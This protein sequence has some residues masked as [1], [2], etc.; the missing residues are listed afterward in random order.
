MSE[1]K[2]RAGRG[3]RGTAL[4]AVLALCLAALCLLA[5]GATYT[6]VAAL[7]RAR[8]VQVTVQRIGERWGE[9]KQEAAT[10]LLAPAGLEAAQSWKRLH[11]D[12]DG[13]FAS[14]RARAAA[15]LAAAAGPEAESSYRLLNQ[16]QHIVH[17]QLTSVAE[18]LTRAAAPAPPGRAGSKLRAL[19][20]YQ[21]RG[22]PP[23]DRTLYAELRTLLRDSAGFD[24]HLERLSDGFGS[25]VQR[26]RR[27]LIGLVALSALV[28]LALLAAVYRDRI[29]YLVRERLYRSTIGSLAEGV[30]I[31]DKKGRLIHANPAARA[32]LGI[33]ERS[34]RLPPPAVVGELFSE[35]HARASHP[36]AVFSVERDGREVGVSRSPVHDR[37]GRRIGDA[38]VLR[39]VTAWMREDRQSRT[40]GRMQ[41]VSSFAGGLA[42]DFNNALAGIQGNLELLALDD[43][44]RLI[45]KTKDAI[46]RARDLSRTLLTFAGSPV[47]RRTGAALSVEALL[48][49]ALAR[50]DRDDPSHALRITREVD[51][52]LPPISGDPARLEE[53]VYAVLR[54][55]AEA[56]QSDAAPDGQR[57][58]PERHLTVTA[59]AGAGPDVDV[60]RVKVIIADTGG[61]IEAAHVHR[62]FDPF[63]STKA[64]HRGL[65]LSLAYAVLHH[66]GGG[67]EIHSEPGQGTR[68]TMSI[69]ADPSS[70]ADRSG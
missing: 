13:A 37:R 16:H 25:L 6:A 7:R 19:P 69:P 4:S 55:A 29:R 35:S 40:E 2:R 26:R 63:F 65:G 53:A 27:V 46:A 10:L 39:D 30:V 44:R 15:E 23:M 32:L 20:R 51:A 56:M 28:L 36:V 59:R 60:P 14:L 41:S 52:D 33:R 57:T 62:A 47:G 66:H 58:S 5:A 31:A 18:Y 42:H 61:G 68:V 67:M 21:R 70:D 12:V 17:R 45:A 11:R 8:S 43:D 38:Y 50:L 3:L 54:N 48:D 24:Y 1:E 22:Q 64:G 34:S 9:L 49:R